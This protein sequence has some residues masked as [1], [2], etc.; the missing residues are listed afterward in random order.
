MLA[1]VRLDETTAPHLAILALPAAAG[2]VLNIGGERLVHA[3]PLVA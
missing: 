1:T 2:Y 3:Q